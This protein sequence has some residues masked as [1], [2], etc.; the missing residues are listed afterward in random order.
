MA[1]VWTLTPARA[2]ALQAADSTEFL[3]ALR[4]AFGGRLGD[5]TAA[6][7]RTCYAL[8]L[9]YAT[10][11]AAAGVLTIG[12]AAQTLHPVAGQGFNLGLRDAWELASVL[13]TLSVQAIADSEPLRRY[14][15]RR[16]VDRVATVSA[17][18][19]L[20]RLFSNDF[21]PLNAA[22]GA[23]MTLLGS[24]APV[25]NFLARRMIFGLHG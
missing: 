5:F 15:A 9:R 6:S 22:R 18:H 11:A 8:T 7:E 19:G 17:T 13:R 2:Q 16:R 12:N 14:R 20:V 21:F 3:A 10:A 25:R 4:A 24:V 23:G 1:L